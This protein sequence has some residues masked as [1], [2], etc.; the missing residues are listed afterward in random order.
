MDE[1]ELGAL[2]EKLC[3]TVERLA[4]EKPGS[5]E[6]NREVVVLRDVRQLLAARR[7]EKDA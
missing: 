3:E 6:Y 1:Q 5:D 2:L 7:K 4:R